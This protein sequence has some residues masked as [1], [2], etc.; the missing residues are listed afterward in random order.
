[1]DLAT[2]KQQFKKKNNFFKI[3]NHNKQAKQEF[4]RLEFACQ[5]IQKDILKIPIF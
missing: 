1:M 5:L 3:F 4:Q 2:L